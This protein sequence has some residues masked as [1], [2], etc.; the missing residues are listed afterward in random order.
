MKTKW[1]FVYGLIAVMFVLAF[2]ALSL[3]GCGNP[4]SGPIDNTGDPNDDNQVPI[5]YT[6]TFDINGGEGAVPDP[7]TVNSGSVITLPGGEG[8]NKAGFI[9]GGWNTKADNTGTNSKAGSSYTV[10]A[11]ITLYARWWNDSDNFA[12]LGLVEK[13]AWI[14]FFAES[15][16]EYTITLNANES[17]VPQTVSCTGR[18]GV[19][20]ILKGDT[21]ERVVSL[22]SNGNLF[23]VESGVTL[24]LDNNITLQGKSDNNASL[25]IV[26]SGGA[27]EMKASAKITGNTKLRD[28]SDR[29]FGS[30]VFVDGGTFTM[31]DGE[32]SNNTTT[33]GG[34]GVEV[35]QGIFIMKDG[36][37]SGNTAVGP[38]GGYGGGV[39]MYQGTFT[40]TDGE[41]SG[42]TASD[43]GGGVNVGNNAT[44]TM[45]GGEICDN[46]SSTYGGGVFMNGGTF[47]MTGGKITGNRCG[48]GSGGVFVYQGTFTMQEGEISGNTAT[49]GGDCGG[50]KVDDNGT[51]IMQGGKISGNTAS[52]NSWAGGGGV[53]VGGTFTMNGGEISSNTASSSNT[54]NASA[55]GGGVLVYGTFTMNGG[56]ISGNTA[57]AVSWTGGGGVY[58]TNGGNF[59]MNSGEI[60]GN[61]ATANWSDGGGVFVDNSS[62][63]TFRIVTG[64]VYGSGA[65]ANSNT[66]SGGAALTNN[67]TAQ[68]GTFSGTTWVSKGNLTTTGD[69]IRVVNG[70]LQ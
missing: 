63:S 56:K 45:S 3:T 51:F 23:A 52:G 22:S 2:T 64:T 27:L 44:F 10:T 67:K 43:G 54:A 30:G 34:G 60:S 49:T 8:L 57:T 16:D 35:Y 21:T 29:G 66:A 40:M 19:T 14:E 37:I 4:E 6:V 39:H 20:V 62:N 65:G 7:Q 1:T 38:D 36:K 50:V 12:T 42:N 46:T 18:T 47:T 48:A 15:N 58:V 25:V 69:T 55:G 13:L 61:T 53:E 28:G 31:N 24:V 59:T 70:V 68:H 5:T 32:I 26:N 9:L 17:I 41:I 33:D 11:N